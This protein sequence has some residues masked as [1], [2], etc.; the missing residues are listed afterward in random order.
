MRKLT[1][2]QQVVGPLRQKNRQFIARNLELS[3]RNRE[4][5]STSLS[6]SATSSARKEK[7]DPRSKDDSS[8]STRS[9]SSSKKLRS[10]ISL[11][12]VSIFFILFMWLLNHCLGCK[13]WIYN[14]QTN[15][16]HAAFIC[17][18]T[19]AVII[20]CLLSCIRYHNSTLH[21]NTSE[22]RKD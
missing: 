3:A 2:A 17:S 12:N 6:L 1:E 19:F 4:L 18:L 5:E 7:T 14:C 22:L 16:F 21:I 8:R 10:R 13:L 9:S 11:G 20:D 15:H